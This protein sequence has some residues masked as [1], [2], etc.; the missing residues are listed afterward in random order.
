MQS[1]RLE[2][3][4]LED[5]KQRIKHDAEL[6]LQVKQVEDEKRRESLRKEWEAQQ[7]RKREREEDAHKA[8][9][10]RFKDETRRHMLA[11][12]FAAAE[13]EDALEGKSDHYCHK[14]H[15]PKPCQSC[16]SDTDSKTT[17][18]CFQRPHV[19]CWLNP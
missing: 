4:Q 8:E 10:Q 16:A 18:P 1:Y 15:K 13:I 17:R 9:K 2:Q 3:K 14:H 7:T 19:H 5:E 12:G 11:A 6:E